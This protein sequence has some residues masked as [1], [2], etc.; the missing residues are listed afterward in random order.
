V[1]L[2]LSAVL[3]YAGRLILSNFATERFPRPSCTQKIIYKAFSELS[4]GM[5]HD[6]IQVKGKCLKMFYVLV[7]DTMNK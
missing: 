1:N 3:K 6:I 2:K 5:N 7:N 4:I